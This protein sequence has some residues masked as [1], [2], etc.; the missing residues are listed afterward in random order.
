MEH[1]RF[2][3]IHKER[4][5]IAVVASERSVAVDYDCTSTCAESSSR[6]RTSVSP[7]ESVAGE[8]GTRPDAR[9]KN[10]Y[11]GWRRMPV[12]D[13]LADVWRIHIQKSGRWLWPPMESPREAAS[14]SGPRV[15]LQWRRPCKAIPRQG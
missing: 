3:D 15:S 9:L 8:Q 6:N 12:T 7:S 13:Q 10:E 14:L 1:T 2:V 5:S 4:I 11:I